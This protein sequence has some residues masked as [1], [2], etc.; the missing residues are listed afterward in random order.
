MLSCRTRLV[1][2][3]VMIEDQRDRDDAFY[4]TDSLNSALGQNRRARRRPAAKPDRR[5]NY[6]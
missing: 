4:E 1:A 2:E 5:D 3:S 6:Q